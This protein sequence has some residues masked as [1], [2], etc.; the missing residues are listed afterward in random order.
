MRE[1]LTIAVAQPLCA[2]RDVAANAAFHAAAVRAAGARV[3]LFP[4]LSLTG[5]EL[6]ASAISP[7][8]PRLASLVE[9]CAETGSLALAGAPVR[10]QAG[11]DHIG[12][13]A[14]RGGGATA[15]YHKLW[16]GGAE[17]GRFSPGSQPAVLEVDGWRLGL[18][19]CKDTGIPQHAADTAARGMDVYAASVLETADRGP[20]LDERAR[21]AARDH[22]VWVAVASFAGSTGGGFDRAAGDSAIWSPEGVAVRRAG[23]EPGALARVTLRNTARVSLRAVEEGDLPRLFEFHREPEANAMAAFTAKD[24]SDREAFL[25]H[26]QRVRRS[27]AIVKRVVVVEGDVAGTV[28][29]FEESGRRHVCYWLGKRFWG[30]GI[31]TR[32]LLLFLAEERVRPLYARAAKD[33]LPSLR[34]LEK[35]GFRVSGEARGYANARGCMIEEAVLE[36]GDPG[37]P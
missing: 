28:L 16:L 29:S 11:G 22:G 23:R 8:D 14:V 10:G 24:P 12:T 35:C 7:D 18:A 21:R 17:P 31:A 34:V 37:A 3:V 15:V 9:A 19:I 4:E 13:L 30:Q 32:A 36:L 1:P 27:D 26:W 25:A 2:A 20:V 6:D 5:Y 33:N